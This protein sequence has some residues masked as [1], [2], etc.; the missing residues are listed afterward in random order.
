MF[1]FG[2]LSECLFVHGLV[3]FHDINCDTDDVIIWTEFSNCLTKCAHYPV[4]Q[5]RVI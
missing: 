2:C 3:G 1:A 4:R 5:K